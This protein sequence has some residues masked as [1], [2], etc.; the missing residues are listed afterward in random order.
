MGGRQ[1]YDNVLSLQS[2]PPCVTFSTTSLV[3]LGQMWSMERWEVYLE[4]S[5]SWTGLPSQAQPQAR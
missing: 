3:M 2:H 4:M 5:V 1:L